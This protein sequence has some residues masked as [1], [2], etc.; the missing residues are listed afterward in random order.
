MSQAQLQD[1]RLVYKNKPYFYTLAM[2]H[3]KVKKTISFTIAL[4]R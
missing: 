2:N 4:E 1:L 3:Q